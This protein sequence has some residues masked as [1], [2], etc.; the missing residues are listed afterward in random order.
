MKFVLTALSVLAALV[1]IAASCA[2]NF[3]YW[4]G[5]GETAR[6][7]LIL[8]AV[9]VAAD[10]LKAALPVLI[11][12]AVRAGRIVYAGA[13]SIAFVLFLTASLLASVGFL[14]KTRGAKVGTQE[15]LTARYLLVRQELGELADK[16]ARLSATASVASI[17]ARLKAQQQN[18]RWTST[19]QCTD[20][21]AT[22]S[23]AFCS[24]Y[25]A[26]RERLGTAVAAARL[27]AR[28]NKLRTEVTRLQQMGA[29]QAAD[30]QVQMVA[31]FVPW[32]TASDAKL[33]L[34]MFI[35][36]FIEFGAALGLYLATG[37]SWVASKAGRGKL[38]GILGTRHSEGRLPVPVAVGNK[39]PRVTIDLQPETRPFALKPPRP[40]K[41][42]GA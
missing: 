28:R 10:V 4:S 40:P 26:E 14:N 21:T 38:V 12:L 32:I 16:L 9:S 24:N 23:R 6:E 34:T 41:A 18:W 8:G 1:M 31:R 11:V 37:H 27:T 5:Q 2:L 42:A 36:V 35:A 25:F 22:A 29:T 19:K 13:A 3:D 17:E 39:R 7:S 15:A 33:A 20:A 30:P